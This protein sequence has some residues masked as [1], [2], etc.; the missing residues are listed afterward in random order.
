ME[1]H[2]NLT[3]SS[4][5]TSEGLGQVHTGECLHPCGW[6]IAIVVLSHQDMKNIEHLQPERSEKKDPPR[7]RE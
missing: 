4:C 3:N 5:P 2:L 6:T 7:W 1:E